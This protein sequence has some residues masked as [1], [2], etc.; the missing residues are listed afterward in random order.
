MNVKKRN[1]TAG[2]IY[3]DVD[4]TGASITVLNSDGSTRQEEKLNASH[5]PIL[6]ALRSELGN[7]SNVN[8]AIAYL[9]SKIDQVG[10]AATTT[11]KGI[12]EL[13]TGQ[14]VI[15]G[16][17]GSLAISPLA[18]KS[19]TA[20]LTR[21]GL[22]Q[23]ATTEEALDGTN[24]NKAIVPSTLKAVI[25]VQNINTI[26]HGMIAS[27]SAIDLSHDVEVSA[28]FIADSTYSYMMSIGATFTKRIDEVWEAGT[29]N[30][31]MASTVAL[32]ATTWYHFFAIYNPTTRITDFGFDTD[33]N[34]VNLLS[35]AVGYTVYRRIAVLSTDVNSHIS[36]FEP[37]V[38][39]IQQPFVREN[40]AYGVISATGAKLIG[41]HNWVVAKNSIGQY[42]LNI[43]DDG[44]FFCIS[45]LCSG[46]NA[47][48]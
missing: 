46:R 19:L 25:D 14:E 43:T 33:I 10:G 44:N 40:V 20:L 5:I 34:A 23:L 27:R 18:L 30:G 47:G 1:L 21:A 17:S 45:R 22:I 6:L 41:S 38:N 36:A 2:D 29:N 3:F 7:A 24:T 15:A 31:G 32:A 11:K 8:A 12:V 42:Q 35:D 26:E 9:I 37:V 28:G 48:R 4:G 39:Q 13:A 16:L